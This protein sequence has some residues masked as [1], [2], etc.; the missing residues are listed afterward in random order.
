MDKIYQP[1]NCS[2]YDYLEA[3]ITKN[4]TVQLLISVQ[5]EKEQE[6]ISKFKDLFTKKGE[7]FLVLE[8]GSTIRLDQILFLNGINF[9]A[10][11]YCSF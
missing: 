10:Q 4:E 8:N 7:E 3:A 2:L 6:I 11:N 5:E 9:K 1:I